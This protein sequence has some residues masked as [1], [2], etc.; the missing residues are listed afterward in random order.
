MEQPAAR[1]VVAILSLIGW[2][3]FTLVVCGK[4]LTL[5]KEEYVMASPALGVR[6]RGAAPVDMWISPC[7]R[8]L[9]HHL[10]IGLAAGRV[11]R[12]LAATTPPA[13][14]AAHQRPYT[15]SGVRPSNAEWGGRISL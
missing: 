13:L 12:L 2:T 1:S 3:D 6:E 4:F 10:S 15:S 8:V 9:G 7:F 14:W 5:R 11:M